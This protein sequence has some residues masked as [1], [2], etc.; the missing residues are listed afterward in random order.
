MLNFHHSDEILSQQWIFIT[1]L[2]FHHIKEISSSGTM[3]V[4]VILLSHYG[5]GGGGLVLGGGYSMI[6]ESNQTWKLC[7]GCV[8]TIPNQK[9]RKEMQVFINYVSVRNLSMRSCHVYISFEFTQAYFE[10]FEKKS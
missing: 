1:L 3:F 9:R 5:V 7:W 8:L 10:L 6:T 2:N 4:T